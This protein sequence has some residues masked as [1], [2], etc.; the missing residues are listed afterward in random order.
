MKRQ[1]SNAHVSR[2]LTH[3]V[4]SRLASQNLFP[5]MIHTIEIVNKRFLL[6]VFRFCVNPE[7]ASRFLSVQDDTP[8][9]V[10]MR[11][12]PIRQQIRKS[13]KSMASSGSRDPDFTFSLA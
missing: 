1:L 4:R 12:Q 8:Q 10:M 13:Y 7:P 11:L 6:R 2:Y 9:M 5:D 3:P